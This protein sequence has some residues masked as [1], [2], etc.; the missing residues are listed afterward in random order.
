M[1]FAKASRSHSF[2]IEGRK[3][4]ANLAGSTGDINHP[5]L[6]VGFAKLARFAPG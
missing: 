3:A 6:L 1:D 5:L 2:E 4:G